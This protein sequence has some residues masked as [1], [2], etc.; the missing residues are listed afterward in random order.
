[1]I[2]IDFETRSPVSLPDCGV[3]VYAS[4][5]Q[6]D[7]WCMAW[8][9]DD[10]P[11]P[12]LWRPGEP[13]PAELRAR[14]ERGEKLAAWNAQFE[15]I[16]W[17]RVAV[18]RYGFPVVPLDQWECIM[19]RAAQCGLPLHLADVAAALGSPQ[20]KDAEGARLMRRLCQPCSIRPDG[21]CEWRGT[22]D[23]LAALYRYCQ[24]DV[25]TE[26]ALSRLLP[27]LPPDEQRVYQLDQAINDRGFAVDWELVGALVSLSHYA[28]GRYN[29]RIVQLT[30]GEVLAVTQ[31]AALKKWLRNRGVGLDSVAA[32]VLDA[33]LRDEDWPEDVREVLVLRREGA[34]SS[35]AKLEALMN[36]RD[37]DDRV[38]GTLQY[39]GA[40]T[41]RWAGR[42]PQPQNF[43]RSGLGNPGGWAEQFQWMLDH[44]GLD[45]AWSYLNLIHPPLT[46]I[47]WLLR[48]CII[49]PEGRRLYGGDF[50]SVEARMVAYLAG[51]NEV[52]E[53]F[54]SGKDVYVQMASKIFGVTPDR[55]TKQQR[56]VGKIAVLGLGYGMGAA[57]FQAF[58]AQNGVLMTADE[59]ERIVRLYRDINTPIVEL[60]RS[61]Q[62]AAILAV[63]RP[64]EIITAEAAKPV[65]FFFTSPWLWMILPSGRRLWYF[66]PRLEETEAGVILVHSGWSSQLRQMVTTR[67]YGGLLA[68]NLVQA[69]CRDL[70]V[71]AMRNIE[72]VAP[73]VLTVHDEIL[74]EGDPD[75]DM[76]EF[77][78]AF[79]TRPEWADDFPLGVE[80][81]T[82]SRYVK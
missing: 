23:E 68:E 26:M 80:T 39:H 7:I 12:Q 78:E 81:W 2:H 53:A 8:A 69:V 51:A 25:R 82:D 35:I 67:L 46:T 76:R 15:R 48:P 49:A 38:H 9:T 41:G 28:I 54:R 47:S 43:P 42:G 4:H 61:L 20:Q 27:P 5:P 1:M 19:A 31:T 57:R 58:A 70:L 24:Q 79:R 45:V 22:A 14:L 44:Y 52:V 55:V 34:R 32:A 63:R 56:Q 66:E 40:A 13:F 65:R 36:Y 11:E 75:L 21:T 74:A 59:A 10:A 30:S 50:A 73:V 18:P 33:K 62:R 71:N 16:V 37:V 72:T 29:E 60:W 64:G 17:N 6:T 77:S 3:Y